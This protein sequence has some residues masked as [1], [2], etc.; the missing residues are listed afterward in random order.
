MR[1]RSFARQLA[2]ACRRVLLS[3]PA[4]PAPPEAAADEE[5][6]CSASAGR[7]DHSCHCV[8]ARGGRGWHRWWSQGRGRGRRRRW[9]RSN[10]ERHRHSLLHCGRDG[11]TTLT[12]SVFERVELSDDARVAAAAAISFV[13]APLPGSVWDREE[14]IHSDARRGHA[15]L[16]KARRL[17]AP[18]RLCEG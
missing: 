18:E 1:A 5:E 16:E 11:A 17:M 2:R 14:R 13:A 12:P 7:D 6:E 9:R 4:A 15:E 3:R 10:Y 8:P